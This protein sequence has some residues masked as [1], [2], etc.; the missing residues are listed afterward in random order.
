MSGFVIHEKPSKQIILSSRP[1]RSG[2][3][4]PVFCRRH[5]RGGR[6]GKAGPSTALRSLRSGGQFWVRVCSSGLA[7]DLVNCDENEKEERS[8]VIHLGAASLIS[9]RHRHLGCDRA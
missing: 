8:I 9:E 7:A 6:A 2:V 5:G 4:G 1:E 3:E